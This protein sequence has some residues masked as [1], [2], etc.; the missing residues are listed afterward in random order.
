MQGKEPDSIATSGS[1]SSTFRE[2]LGLPKLPFDESLLP[3]F[4]LPARSMPTPHHEFLPSFALGNRHE[5]MMQDHPMMPFLPKLKF[6]SLD[7]PM[8]NHDREI[9]HTLGLRKLP[10]SLSSFPEKHKKVLENIMLRTG[11]GSSNMFRRKSKKDIWSEEEL[12]FLWVGVR[13]HGRGNW[14]AMRRDPRLRFSRHKNAEDLAAKWEEE[15]SRVFDIP[16]LAHSSSAKSTQPPA[17]PGISDGMMARALHGSRLIAPLKFQSHLTDMKLGFCDGPSDIPHFESEQFGLR[18]DTVVPVPVWNSEKPPANFGGDSAGRPSERPGT[19][20]SIPVEKPFLPSSLGTVELGPL[21]PYGS[22]NSVSKEK[23][24]VTFNK[25]RK[26]PG[27]FDGSFYAACDPR[28]NLN[29]ESTSS[30][31]PVNSKGMSIPHE[32]G[33]GGGNPKDKLPHWL[34]EAVNT[35][36]KPPAAELPH[37][38]SAIAQSVRLLYGEDNPTIP[39][40]VIP[41]PPPPEPKDPRRG[42]KKKKKHRSH[43]LKT[44]VRNVSGSGQ[45]LQGG[46]RMDNTA[47]SSNPLPF[48]Q[49]PQPPQASGRPWMESDLNL[50]P[51]SSFHSPKN[52]SLPKKS[53]M[54]L[55]PSPE[56][57]KLVASCVAPG[58]HSSS[59]SG[60]TASSFLESKI[61]LPKS[62]DGG[63]HG[64]NHGMGTV[65]ESP[66][67]GPHNVNHVMDDGTVRES[68]PVDAQGPD[69]KQEHPD[70]DDSSKTESDRSHEDQPNVVNEVSSEETLSDHP[71]NDCE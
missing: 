60:L 67:T 53:S 62:P 57:L 61:S 37:T 42:L 40:F 23:E 71:A 7:G 19:S 59:V 32:E 9:E 66:S 69:R 11:P 39:P 56:V 35:P 12:D 3:K 21:E 36:S 31:L 44:F 41:D 63:P 6:P 64:V 33:V 15:E 24:E 49:L 5:A 50:P 48:P 54:G 58:P 38:V 68:P 43:M 8:Y 18:N 10:A 45:N 30:V 13:R 47:S 14:Y 29:D 65:R 55:L 4:P 2:R 1:G 16:K 52:P 22:N 27:I 34:R 20:S 17:F 26:F 46:L 25:Y 28:S 51:F 70:S